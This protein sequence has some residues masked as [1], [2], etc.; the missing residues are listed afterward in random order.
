MNSKN[1]FQKKNDPLS[2]PL[3]GEE[4][5]QY[6]EKNKSQKS[7]DGDQIC[8]GAGYGS[9]TEEGIPSCRLDVFSAELIKAQKQKHLS[10]NKGKAKKEILSSYNFETLEKIARF[11]CV[12]GEAYLH[13]QISEVERFFEDNKDEIK[14]YLEDQFGS[15]YLVKSAERVGGDNSHWK[16]R[17]V[18]RF[19]EIIASEELEKNSA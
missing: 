19:I 7:N 13:L 6:I 17:A 4:L 8:I 10:T 9:L 5:L 11:G 16:H 15:G 18:W 12:S 1:K 3:V 14:M 2:N